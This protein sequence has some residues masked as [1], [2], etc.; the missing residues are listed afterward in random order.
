MKKSKKPIKENVVNQFK[1]I[2]LPLL[3]VLF[4][5]FTMSISSFYIS[6][7]L[8]LA[9]MKQDGVNLVK[10]V[11]NQI[12]GSDIALDV[13]NEILEEK[14]KIAEEMI[15]KNEKNLSDEFLMEISKDLH[16]DELNWM[17]E[18][19]E[20]LYTTIEAYRGWIPFEGHALHDFIHS[21]DRELIEAIRPDVKSGI[22]KKY[23]AMKN[24]AGYL[25]QAGI[26]AENVQKLTKTFSYQ[27]SIEALMKKENIVYATLVDKNLKVIADGDREEIRMCYDT[28][29]EK[30]LKEALKGKIS[31][32]EWC[33]DKIDAKVLEILAPV[34][35]NGE[36]IGVLVIGLS[37]KRVHDAVY[38][39]FIISFMIALIM[40]LLFLWVQNRNIIKPVNRLNQK[41]NQIDVEKDITYRLQL[42]E[43][44]TFFGLTISMNNLLDKMASYLFQL[45]ENQEELE[46]SNEELVAAYE[47]LTA[48][49]EELRAQYDE[50]QSYTEKLEN[51][52]QRYAIAIKG[53]NSAVWEVD[54]SDQTVYFSHEFKEIV[55]R[56]F[57]EKVEIDQIVK[58]L[59]TIED[60][61]NLMEAFLA[62]KNGDSEEI[63]TQ[64]RIKNQDDRLKWL[65]VRGKGI[66]DEQQNLKK[67]S[68]I[69]LDITELKEQEAYIKKLAYND[70]LTELPNR[71][72]F[73]EKL[74]KALHK[75]QSG[76]VMLLDLDNF[77]E[78]NDTLGHTYGDK[79]L[80]KVARGLK[81]IR[82]EKM[83]LSRLG[84]DEFLVLIEGEE[85]IIEIENYAKKIIQI[86]KDKCM[87]ESDEIYISASLGVTRYPSDS[88]EV[89]Q[90]IMNADM[91]M[92]KVKDIGKN[93]YMFFNK[94]MIENLKEQIHIGKILRE[95][96]TEDG[97]KLVYQPQV[98]TY[99]GKIIGFEALIRLKNHNISPD[100]FIEAAEEN[101]MIIEIGR[102]VTKEAISQIVTWKNKGLPVKPIAINFSA[103]Q[104][105]DTNYIAFLENT[106]KEKN[107]EVKYIEIEI[108]ESIFLDEKEET[109]VFLNRLKKL[110]I[111]I[112]L[113]DFGTGYSSLSYLTFLPV[114][115]IKLD[116][117][118]CDKF[119]EI[120]NIAVMDNIIS[121]AHSLNLEVTAEGI[122]DMEQYKRLK[123]AKCNYIQGYLFSKPVEALE[124]E[125]IYGDNFLEKIND[126]A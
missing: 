52:K 20:I 7:N 103:K 51:L 44:G 3:I 96:I 95:A 46:A 78:I 16:I 12:E 92:Y 58:A 57:S 94:E 37:M 121:L 15:I 124:S 98:C 24:S 80:K 109:I 10:Q 117:S 5:T 122:E 47:Q 42:V 102:W 108:T 85:D 6:R 26:L 119:L 49:E 21:K 114:D 99:T 59:F 126:K 72:S 33:Y 93:N 63:Y 62:Y 81:H 45:K 34:N 61:Q 19:G 55:G 43:K 60:Q 105:K 118:L 86:F 112:A 54:I 22:P 123:V 17:N 106:L 68:G 71:R 120:E 76:A 65:L 91:A 69:L 8:L 82:D 13:I 39:I 90:L 53:T 104:L 38:R 113:D 107:V 110:G 77:K 88:N 75:D 111:K 115:K 97:F 100:V 28:N 66:Y 1:L 116:K 56:T 25:V 73:L 84:G 89:S 36:I 35:K 18:K 70:S 67:I 125:K 9:Q 41:I 79:V 64:V 30:E 101:G 87:I 48:S 14:I 4:T 27:T 40:F 83:F 2:Y 32:I 11:T 23:G 31:M 50:I 29:K 74:E